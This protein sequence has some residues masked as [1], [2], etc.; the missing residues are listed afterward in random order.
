MR[1]AALDGSTHEDHPLELVK[2][3]VV[4][5]NQS[6]DVYQGTDG[7]QSDLI[8]VFPDLAQDVIHGAW[9]RGLGELSAFR[10]TTLTRGI[11]NMRGRARCHNDIRAAGLSEKTIQQPGAS[12]GVTERSRDS[13]NLKFRTAQRK[14]DGERVIDI[15]SDIGIDNYFL[16]NVNGSGSLACTNGTEQ[17]Q[18]GEASKRE[19]PCYSEGRDFRS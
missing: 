10:I 2:D 7:D 15:V 3:L 4:L 13:Q 16:G 14:R 11:G 1:V 9:M 17:Y 12:F 6:S 8:G 5:V 19:S 18:T